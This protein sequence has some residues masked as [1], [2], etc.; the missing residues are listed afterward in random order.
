MAGNR[1]D[2]N[3]LLLAYSIQRAL[4]GRT[5][6]F[7]RGVKRARFAVLKDIAAPGVLV[8]VGFVSN[9]REERLMLD[10]GYRERIVRGIA[11]GIVIYHRTMSRR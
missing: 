10:P 8:E 3:N 5:R 6:A 7:D 4:L 2:A 9:P 11:E 1:F